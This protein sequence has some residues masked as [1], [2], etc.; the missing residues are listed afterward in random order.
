MQSYTVGDAIMYHCSA[1]IDYPTV[2]NYHKLIIRSPTVGRLWKT[3]VDYAIYTRR[4]C[5][6][7]VNYN[8]DKKNKIENEN[9]K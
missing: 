9:S 1:Q 5:H 3:I 7:C 4:T 8:F 6:V 2:H